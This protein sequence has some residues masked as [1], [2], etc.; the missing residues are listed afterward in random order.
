MEKLKPV[1]LLNGILINHIL[2]I[3]TKKTLFTIECHIQI[4]TKCTYFK[5]NKCDFQRLAGSQS[6]PEGAQ[7]L[8]WV[9]SVS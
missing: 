2:L 6:C 7:K 9:L 1:I 5:R 4:F 8:K 3:F